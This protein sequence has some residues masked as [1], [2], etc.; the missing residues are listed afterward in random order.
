MIDNLL[1]FDTQK[2]PN[3]AVGGASDF[4]S[5][6]AERPCYELEAPTGRAVYIMQVHASQGA[7]L[8]IHGPVT[9]TEITG[10]LATPSI[11]A[12]FGGFDC[13]AEFRSGTSSSAANT[14]GWL[15]DLG[16]TGAYQFH[17]YGLY[18]APG[19]ICVLKANNT[20]GSVM[21]GFRWLELK[22]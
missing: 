19:D 12:N 22:I 14:E 5:G 6:G 2:A 7:D 4:V 20:G 21:A 9:S 10:S 15:V 1:K 16:T 3:Y 11:P 17:P 13:T 8:Y 18:L